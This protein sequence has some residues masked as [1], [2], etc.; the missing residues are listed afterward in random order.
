MIPTFEDDILGCVLW[1]AHLKREN[2]G[3]ARAAWVKANER[4]AGPGTFTMP[5]QPWLGPATA[6]KDLED[7]LAV[8]R[9]RHAVRR[10]LGRAFLK[11]E[12]S[13]LL[14]PLAGD[15]NPTTAYREVS[16]LGLELLQQDSYRE[17]VLGL[18][19]VASRWASSVVCIYSKN[20]SGVG[21][22]F[23]VGERLIA[24][25]RHVPEDLG[26][27]EICDHEGHEIEVSG[28][29]IYPQQTS[30]DLDL[31]LIEIRAQPAGMTPMRLAP[32]PDLL[33]EV[34]VFG[35]PPVPFTTK[36]HLL[37]NRG[38]VSAIVD[39]RTDYQAIIVT[40]LLRGGNSGGPIVDRRGRVV[41]VASRNLFNQM[42]PDEQSLNEGLGYSVATPSEW[43]S[44]LI[45]RRV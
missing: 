7:V 16:E 12:Q 36:P 27:F 17:F 20:E 6:R 44:D 15:D 2:D 28:A 38:E 34:V 4:S 43:V 1:F 9:D 33:D 40:C 37:A 42:L 29:P 13:L 26:E 21:S 5:S 11:L 22:G 19:F 18:P 14:E 35:F 41:G 39:L 25:A 24:T 31:A 30:G 45:E 3:G 32:H 8:G 10:Q 23:L